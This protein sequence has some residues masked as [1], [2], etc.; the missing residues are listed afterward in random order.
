MGMETRGSDFKSLKYNVR[1][2]AP[3]PRWWNWTSNENNERVL[4]IEGRNSRRKL[5]ER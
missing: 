1:E 4:R 3:A 5:D 2:L